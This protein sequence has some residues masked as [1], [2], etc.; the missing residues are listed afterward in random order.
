M[1]SLYPIKIKVTKGQENHSKN[2]P[3]ELLNFV[4]ELLRHVKYENVI[5]GAVKNI[6]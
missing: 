3:T 1:I 2:L 4:T 5:L 6:T